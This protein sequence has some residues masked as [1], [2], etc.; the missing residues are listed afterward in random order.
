M[1]QG[2]KRI[3]IERLHDLWSVGN[4]VPFPIVIPGILLRSHRVTQATRRIPCL[5]FT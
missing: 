1:T 2:A 4:V 3:L 5:P